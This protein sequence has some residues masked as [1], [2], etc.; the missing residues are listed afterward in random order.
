[1]WAQRLPSIV[2]AGIEGCVRAGSSFSMEA[3]RFAQ[4]GCFMLSSTV[5]WFVTVAMVCRAGF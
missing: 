3:L 2:A 1:M 5:C 4:V